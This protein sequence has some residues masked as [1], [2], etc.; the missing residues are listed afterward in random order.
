MKGQKKQKLK[1]VNNENRGGGEA[2]MW[3]MF[4][5]KSRTVAIKAYL[6]F[7]QAVFV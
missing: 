1:G 5:F 4:C 7:E 6:S 2:G 3:Q